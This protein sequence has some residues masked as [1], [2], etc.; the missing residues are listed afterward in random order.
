[1]QTLLILLLLF[2]LLLLLGADASK[3]PSFRRN[4]RETSHS[5][6]TGYFP[7]IDGSSIFDFLILSIHRVMQVRMR[8][9]HLLCFSCTI[10]WS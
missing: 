8:S 2:L 9:C 4:S 6:S 5:D 3:A 1:M 7:W 10:V